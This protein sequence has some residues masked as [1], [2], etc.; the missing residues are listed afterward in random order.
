MFWLSGRL[1]GMEPDSEEI[2]RL[3]VEKEW[4]KGSLRRLSR[5]LE[6]LEVPEDGSLFLFCEQLGGQYRTNYAGGLSRLETSIQVPETPAPLEYEQSAEEA[7]A[8]PEAPADQTQPETPSGGI[9]L[10]KLLPDLLLGLIALALI[11][12]AIWKRS[13]QPVLVLLLM[14]LVAALVILRM[15]GTLYIF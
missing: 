9:D 2:L 10:W 3:Q 12:A 5:E 11:V 6:K 1:R 15:G 13:F 8:E 14:L 7:A 4:Y